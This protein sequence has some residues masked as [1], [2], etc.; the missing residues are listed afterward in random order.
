MVKSR[1]EVKLVIKAGKHAGKKGTDEDWKDAVEQM[2]HM[3]N[4]V[5][6]GQNAQM[7]KDIH[8]ADDGG[9]NKD[10]VL[11][12]YNFGKVVAAVMMVFFILSNVYALL[13][14][15]IPLLF[16]QKTNPPTPEG[17]LITRPFFR[18]ITGG[19]F[20][21]EQIIAFSELAGLFVLILWTIIC[22]IR[23]KKAE[24]GDQEALRWHLTTV[25]FFVYIQWLSC[26]SAM[27]LLYYATPAVLSTNLTQEIAFAQEKY[28][29]GVGAFG[30]VKDLLKYLGFVIVCALVGF[31]SFLVKTRSASQGILVQQEDLTFNAGIIS[32]MFLVQMLGVVNVYFFVQARLFTFIFG[33]EDSVMTNKEKANQYLWQAQLAKKVY[34]TFGFMKF[35]VVMF[36]YSDFDFQMLVL[37]DDAV[38]AKEKA[39]GYQPP[40]TA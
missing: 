38:K 5:L 32:L 15:D 11:K 2:R 16:G 39:L 22:S 7:L 4:L 10:E 25:V 24:L 36:A 37:N 14:A 13:T 9:V 23:A 12:L 34:E 26:Y 29:H 1:G 3:W 17:F 8:I 40:K 30:S 27:G 6:D 18:M 31:D 21:T 35:C 28:A 33:G 19:L 20:T